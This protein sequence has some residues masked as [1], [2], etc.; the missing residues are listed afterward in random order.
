[1]FASVINLIPKCNKEPLA[2]SCAVAIP[3]TLKTKKGLRD[4]RNPLILLVGLP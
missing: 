3:L 1:M 4:M 2:L